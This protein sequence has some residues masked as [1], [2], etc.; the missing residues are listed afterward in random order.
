MSV[1]LNLPDALHAQ[2]NGRVRI[3]LD[4]DR[5]DTVG[6]VLDALKRELPAAHRRIVTEQGELRPHINVFVGDENIRWTGGLATPVSSGAE[7]HVLPAVS[8]G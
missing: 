1:V 7:I 3:E 6:D 2:A 8:G 5:G 4:A